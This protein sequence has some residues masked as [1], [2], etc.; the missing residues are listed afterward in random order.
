MPKPLKAVYNPDA[1]YVVER[2]DYDYG[3]GSIGY[4]I[5]DTRDATYHRLC[6]VEEDYVDDEGPAEFNPDDP[7]DRGQAKMDAD[8]IV[9]AL[10][11]YF[12]C[13]PLK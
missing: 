6:A 11:L 12:I 4:E 1:P 2:H 10:N 8:L 5:W 13:G 9:K 7:P 3:D